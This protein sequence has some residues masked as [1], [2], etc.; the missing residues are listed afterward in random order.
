MNI[1]IFNKIHNNI[2]DSN[3]YLEEIPTDTKILSSLVNNCSMIV[4][5]INNNNTTI[6]K[7]QKIFGITECCETFIGN[8]ESYEN[9]KTINP[10]FL[11]DDGTELK[12]EYIKQAILIGFMPKS[13]NAFLSFFHYDNFIRYTNEMD[14][15]IQLFIQFCE[16]VL[17]CKNKVEF[18]QTELKYINEIN[19]LKKELTDVITLRNNKYTKYSDLGRKDCEYDKITNYVREIIL[20]VKEFR[21]NCYIEELLNIQKHKQIVFITTDRF[22]SYQCIL[23]NIPVINFVDEPSSLKIKKG[24]VPKPLFE[25]IKYMTVYKDGFIKIMGSL[26]E[27]FDEENTITEAV[28]IQRI[29]EIITEIMRL[30][31]IRMRNSFTYHNNYLL[32]PTKYI[33]RINYESI[34]IFGTT[35][36]NYID[37]PLK[38][39]D[40]FIKDTLD[41]I[42]NCSY[43][44]TTYDKLISSLLI[45]YDNYYDDRY[46]IIHNNVILDDKYRK[47]M[48]HYKIAGN[49]DIKETT[50]RNNKYEKNKYENEK[51]QTTRNISYINNDIERYLRHTKSKI[52]DICPSTFRFFFIKYFFDTFKIATFA[53]YIKFYHPEI[54]WDFKQIL[55][56]KSDNCKLINYKTRG[57]Y[58]KVV[59][60]LNIKKSKSYNS[61][62]GADY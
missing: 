11:T 52:S 29:K 47:A 17:E 15:Q 23:K 45:L 30:P 5:N 57:D 37:N 34:N 25:L 16:E 21:Y 20:T 12:L 41:F 3:N 22:L 10:Q 26:R 40:P 24:Y 13:K 43:G 42:F 31:L 44:I 51:G 60:L 48:S 2:M 54:Q 32:D 55:L 58:K 49:F 1:I 38:N 27:I 18:T 36:D 14:E 4:D 56:I 46:D 61:D 28:T 33:P 62:S 59:R 35:N 53:R 6:T 39:Y 50:S 19:K 9:T 8:C 7:L